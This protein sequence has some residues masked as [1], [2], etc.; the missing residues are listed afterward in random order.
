MRPKIR[1][2]N[3]KDGFF[4]ITSPTDRAQSPGAWPFHQRQNPCAWAPCQESPNTQSPTSPSQ[5]VA[6]G[7]RGTHFGAAPSAN[8]KRKGIT[9]STRPE[10]QKLLGAAAQ[11]RR[12]S[13]R[14]RETRRGREAKRGRSKREGESGKVR[15][16]GEKRE[17][18]KERR[19]GNQP[20]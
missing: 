16:G 4:K 18:G 8:C 15:E 19:R 17:E 7:S 2:R 12:E 10:P 3:T 1:K 11:T 14:E 6:N 13:D 5:A 9:F 20:G